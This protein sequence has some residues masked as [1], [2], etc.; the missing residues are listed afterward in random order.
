MRCLV[1]GR[2]TM[3]ADLLR[4]DTGYPAPDPQEE[5]EGYWEQYQD[6]ITGAV[7]N[8]WIPAGPAV[9]NPDTPEVDLEPTVAT[10]SCIARGITDGG[11][12]MGATTEQFGDIYE[13]VDYVKLWTPSSVKITKRDRVTNIR[14]RDTGDVLWKDEEYSPNPDRPTVF[15]V[16][17]VIPILD[18]FNRHVENYVLLE[19]AD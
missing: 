17:G 13:N 8:H 4:K 18:P 14:A 12:R 7:L 11:I 16:N 19:K 6:P 2:M 15:N 9:D 3:R 10:F 1:S 5:P